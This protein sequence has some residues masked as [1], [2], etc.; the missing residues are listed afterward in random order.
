MEPIASRQWSTG[1]LEDGLACVRAHEPVQLLA[2]GDMAAQGDRDQ[3]M[4]ESL[5]F[6]CVC[7]HCQ[8]TA[9]YIQTHIFLCSPGCSTAIGADPCS[10]KNE[11]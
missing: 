7:A 3:Q 6:H 11:R 8:R 9:E 2:A 5:T 4:K 10:E 1:T